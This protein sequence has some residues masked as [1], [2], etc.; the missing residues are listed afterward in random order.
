MSIET[1]RPV[2]DP[3]MDRAYRVAEVTLGD[4]IRGQVLESQACVVD[5]VLRGI[6]G[7][8]S[9]QVQAVPVPQQP[10]L[11]RTAKWRAVSDGCVKVGVPRVEMGVEMH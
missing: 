6:Y 9:S 4:L 1:Y 3:V 7:P 2:P 8:A 10:F 5:Q 11:S